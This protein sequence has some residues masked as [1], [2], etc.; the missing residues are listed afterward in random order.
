MGWLGRSSVVIL[1]VH[2]QGPTGAFSHWQ[3]PPTFS[4]PS[5]RARGVVHQLRPCRLPCGRDLDGRS[6][7]G[8]GG[9]EPGCGGGAPRGC[10]LAQIARRRPRTLGDASLT[11][12]L[13]RHRCAG[14]MDPPYLQALKGVQLRQGPQMVRG[15]SRPAQPQNGLRVV[16]CFSQGGP[17]RASRPSRGGAGCRQKQRIEA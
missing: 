1:A 13:G 5:R 12:W 2:S 3:R 17:S 16:S 6:A 7:S 10:G 14:S 15:K 11:L 8:K 9:P 4:R